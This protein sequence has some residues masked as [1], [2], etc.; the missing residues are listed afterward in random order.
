MSLP[1]GD[2]KRSAAQA[3]GFSRN[4]AHIDQ[5]LSAH[6]GGLVCGGR[7]VRQDGSVTMP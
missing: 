2:L 6:I 5:V 4:G 3:L 1:E 7:L